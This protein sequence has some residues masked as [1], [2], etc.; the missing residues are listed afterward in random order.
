ME[1]TQTNLGQVRIAKMSCKSFGLDNL[2]VHDKVPCPEEFIDKY[3]DDVWVF[4][5]IRQEPVRL[6]RGEYTTM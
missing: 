3:S 4:S 2:S 5:Q 1:N 6:L